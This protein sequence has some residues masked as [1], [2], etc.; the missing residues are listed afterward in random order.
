MTNERSTI[1]QGYL[2]MQQGAQEPQLR[3]SVDRGGGGG[4]APAVM[5]LM[6]TVER[7]LALR[8]GAGR[9]SLH[10]TLQ[11]KRP[12]AATTTFPAIRSF[13]NTGRRNRLI[14]SAASMCW[15]TSRMNYLDNILLDLKVDHTAAWLL[16]HSYRSGREGADRWPQCASDP[17]AVIVV[18]AEA[19][20]AIYEISHLERRAGW[21][22][23]S[24]RAAAA[25]CGKAVASRVGA[26]AAI[27]WIN[28]SGAF[29]LDAT[30]AVSSS[31]PSSYSQNIRGA[32]RRAAAPAPFMLLSPSDGYPA[33]G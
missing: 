5:S 29:D 19:V 2:A 31:D 9:C 10:E 12:A 14:S 28:P 30:K 3:G 26:K 21:L 17:A 11:E 18:A 1:S 22:Q 33:G 8:I 13:L 32:A 25:I 4:Y 23:G 6:Q 20:R 7:P 16:L 15:S 24:D 27:T